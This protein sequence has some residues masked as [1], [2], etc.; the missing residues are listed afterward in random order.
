MKKQRD[1]QYLYGLI[2]LGMPRPLAFIVMRPWKAKAKNDRL[3]WETSD[4]W[5]WRPMREVRSRK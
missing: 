2:R 3:F 1:R 4:S 5:M